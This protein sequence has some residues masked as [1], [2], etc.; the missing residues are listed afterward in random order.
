MRVLNYLIELPSE[1]I[2]VNE[3]I[4]GDDLKEEEMNLY[5]AFNSDLESL[6]R[7][8]EDETEVIRMRTDVKNK[9]KN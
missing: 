8:L 2:K 9:K 3:K 4:D 5:S 1:L 7:K 6:F